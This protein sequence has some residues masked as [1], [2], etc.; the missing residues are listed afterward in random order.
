MKKSEQAE[1]TCRRRVATKSKMKNEHRK[2]AV[3]NRRRMEGQSGDV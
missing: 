1:M 3:R 2:G